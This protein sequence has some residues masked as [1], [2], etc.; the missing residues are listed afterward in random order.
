M[1]HVSN[2]CGSKVRVSIAYLRKIPALIPCQFM[3]FVIWFICLCSLVLPRIKPRVLRILGENI[4]VKLLSSC[5]S[6]LNPPMAKGLVSCSQSITLPS[7]IFL[8]T[9]VY[10]SVTP[11]ETQLS[12]QWLF[13]KARYNHNYQRKNF[14]FTENI[15][16]SDLS[17]FLFL[18][19]GNLFN[20]LS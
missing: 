7:S 19:K 10:M 1:A 4:P 8:A 11:K 12:Y 15:T 13:I 2:F 3:P 9:S 14:H 20:S 17:C 16:K 5:L 6:F 18:M